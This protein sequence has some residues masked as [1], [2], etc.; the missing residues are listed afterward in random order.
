MIYYVHR[1][2]IPVQLVSLFNEFELEQILCGLS[3]IN[4]DDWKKHAVMIGNLPTLPMM[5]ERWAYLRCALVVGYRKDE[6]KI[7]GDWLWEILQEDFNNTQ[8]GQVLQF[9]TGS[10]QVTSPTSLITLFHAR[11]LTQETFFLVGARVISV[12]A[13]P[14]HSG[15]GAR[16][17]ER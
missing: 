12:P 10:A 6:D 17:E 7:Q 15:F 16:P 14:V 5:K 11:G 13:P 2:Q 4:V 3:E 8:R 1:K 9:V